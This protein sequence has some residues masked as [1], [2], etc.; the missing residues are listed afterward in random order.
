MLFDHAER[1]EFVYAHKWL[2]NDLLI[3]DNQVPKSRSNGLS[4]LEERLL[5]R[6]T[7]TEWHN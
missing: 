7:I 6:L 1:T 2:M 4:G 5:R 3:W